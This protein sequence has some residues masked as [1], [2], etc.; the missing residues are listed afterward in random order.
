MGVRWVTKADVDTAAHEKKID[1]L[2]GTLSGNVGQDGP[3]H[4]AV[5]NAHVAIVN[6]RRADR[7][8][9]NLTIATW[10][11]VLSSVVLAIVTAV[12]A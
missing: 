7:A 2:I 8:A 12:N 5:L 4:A 3:T 1:E 6:G 10:A 11:L 9:H